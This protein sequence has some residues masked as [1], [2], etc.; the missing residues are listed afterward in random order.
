MALPLPVLVLGGMILSPH[1]AP[2]HFPFTLLINCGYVYI[3][4]PHLGFLK[5][6]N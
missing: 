3:F 5:D 6:V 4:L 2:V 1:I